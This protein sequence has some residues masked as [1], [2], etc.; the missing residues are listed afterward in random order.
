MTHNQ[1]QFVIYQEKQEYALNVDCWKS[2][3]NNQDSSFRST[4]NKI[5][6]RL[7]NVQFIFS[8][9]LMCVFHVLS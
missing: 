6:D 2:N 7:H 8:C 5:Q 3:V 4:C 9:M 1:M